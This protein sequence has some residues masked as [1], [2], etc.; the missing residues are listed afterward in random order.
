MYYNTA[1]KQS[2]YDSANL[3]F[4]VS[5]SNNDYVTIIS[6]EPIFTTAAKSLFR[7]WARIVPAA[8]WIT[9]IFY[10]SAWAALLKD[11]MLAL[12]PHVHQISLVKCNRACNVSSLRAK[13]VSLVINGSLSVRLVTVLSCRLLGL[14]FTITT[15]KIIRLLCRQ[16]ICLILLHIQSYLRVLINSVIR[17]F[18]FIMKTITVNGIRS[19]NLST[20]I[21]SGLA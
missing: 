3:I 11:V 4:F 14:Q 10:V 8:P 15:Q 2:H 7:L 6:T 12:H 20:I 17:C 19:F 13:V 16:C 18:C 21:I 1:L 9:N 5:R